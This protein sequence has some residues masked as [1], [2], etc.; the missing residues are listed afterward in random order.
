MKPEAPA[1]VVLTKYIKSFLRMP[2]PWKKIKQSKAFNC[3]WGL[4]V[5]SNWN[6]MTS[7]PQVYLSPTVCEEPWLSGK[8]VIFQLRTQQVLKVETSSEYLM[9]IKNDSVAN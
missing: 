2:N 6:I 8:L 3:A 5:A 7:P 1:F 4:E 9:N